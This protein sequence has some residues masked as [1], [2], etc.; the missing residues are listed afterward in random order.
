MKYHPTLMQP[1]EPDLSNTKQF[2]QFV[3]NRIGAACIRLHET[4]VKP[5]MRKRGRYAD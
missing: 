3:I 1:E 2:A 5:S 4:E